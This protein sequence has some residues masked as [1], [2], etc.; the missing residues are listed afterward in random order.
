LLLI[1]CG[2]RGWLLILRCRNT[3]TAEKQQRAAGQQ[4]GC[5]YAESAPAAAGARDDVDGPFHGKS[6]QSDELLGG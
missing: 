4:E 3:T 1:L 5:R 6:P 2:W